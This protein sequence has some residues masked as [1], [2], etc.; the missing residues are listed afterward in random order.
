MLELLAGAERTGRTLAE[1]SR[2]LGVHKATCTPML[3]E[4]VRVGWLVRN[5]RR[6]TYHLGPRLVPIGAAARSAIDIV[7]LTRPRAVAL[8]EEFDAACMTVASSLPDLVVV[9]IASGSPAGRRWSS[10]PT[11]IGLRMGDAIRLRPPLGAVLVAWAEPEHV[12]RW[13]A[14]GA[15]GDRGDLTRALEAIR[16]RGYAVEEF[17]PTPQSLEELIV[18]AAG[19][20]SGSRR[21]HRLLDQ[22]VAS[23]GAEVLVEELSPTAMYHPVS[24]NAPVFDAAGDVTHALCLTDLR[25]PVSGEVVAAMGRAMAESA[26]EVSREL[27]HR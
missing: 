17:R 23:L 26:A 19:D 1:I 21:A 2:H 8:A 27:G 5:P 14:L 15:E 9:D 16:A 6:K 24:V 3:A 13:L 11:S 22:G 10:G 18:D 20:L 25:G 7:D 4:L 12:D